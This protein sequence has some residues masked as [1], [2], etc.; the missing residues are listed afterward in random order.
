MKA[1]VAFYPPPDFPPPEP[2]HFSSQPA[3]SPA[4]LTHAV[5]LHSGCTLFRRG[6]R[7]RDSAKRGT[8]MVRRSTGR[9]RST[10]WPRAALVALVVL[11]STSVGLRAQLPTPPTKAWQ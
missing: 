1:A 2:R 11:A 5:P 10:L 9:N 3:V 7:V 8:V 6:C 4:V